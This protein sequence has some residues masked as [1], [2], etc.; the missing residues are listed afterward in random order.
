M[1]RRKHIYFVALILAVAAI[2]SSCAYDSY[3]LSKTVFIPDYENPGLPIYSEWGY[4]TFG[5]YIDRS[6]FVSTDHILPSKI[7][8]NPDT[9]NIRLSGF[10]QSVSTT[11][12][13]SVIGYAPRDYPDLISL[14]DSTINLKEDNCIIT[15]GKK[16]E[17]AVKL[18]IIDG[19]ITFKKAQ[20][21]YVD[22]ELSKTILSGTIQF[23]TF[24]DGEPV[25]IT[26]GRF[27][28]GIGYENF[29]YYVR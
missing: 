11:L 1:E 18:P 3:E 8:V 4:N 2:T 14:N 12:T 20:N 23:R 6:T 26:N 10:Y 16:S 9:F 28:L 17:K 24:F 7:I 29:Y 13:I 27:D 19:Y 21:L 15:L 25:A 22:N 5:M